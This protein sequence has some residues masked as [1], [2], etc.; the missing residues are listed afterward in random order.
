MSIAAH[1]SGSGAAFLS[2][3][4]AISDGL[5]RSIKFFAGINKR[6]AANRSTS[7]APPVE[8]ELRIADQYFGSAKDRGA[9][10]NARGH[11]GGS[12]QFGLDI[13]SD[14]VLRIIKRAACPMALGAWL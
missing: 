13:I 10:I 7:L 5:A 2:A 11:R 9:A 3:S 14:P 6:G 12:S 8:A 1:A 4:T